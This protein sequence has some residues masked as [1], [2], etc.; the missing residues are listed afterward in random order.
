MFKLVSMIAV[1]AASTAST[2]ATAK[3]DEKKAEAQVS[4]SFADAKSTITGSSK[5]LHSK[6]VMPL[7]DGVVPT[8]ADI[9]TD[10]QADAIKYCAQCVFSGSEFSQSTAATK[11]T[12]P[13]AKVTALEAAH[14]TKKT[15]VPATVDEELTYKSL[16]DG[17]EICA[18]ETAKSTTSFT[19][20]NGVTL[21]STVTP[22]CT[23]TYSEKAFVA[24][25]PT[26]KK[27]DKS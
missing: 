20:Q 7:A 12:V 23:T 21:E 1:A 13:A 19:Y 9:N 5:I 17:L 4:K 11:C 26:G 8:F 2:A 24:G 22:V 6:F 16:F 27:N 3:A 14:K 15:A 25:K 18:G 10:V